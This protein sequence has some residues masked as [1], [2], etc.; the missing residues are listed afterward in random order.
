MQ[1]VSALPGLER[2]LEVCRRRAHPLKHEPPLPP[3][4]SGADFVAGQPMDPQLA[5]LHSRVGYLWVR[6]E[7]YVFPERHAH[8]PDLHQVNSRWRQDWAEPFGS[9]LVFAKDDRLAYCYATVPSLGDAR[10]LQPVVWV[11]VYEALYAVPVA[12]SLDAFLDTY[13]RYLEAAPAF[14]ADDAP[15][16]R[17]FP[18]SASPFI[19]RD[20]EL[21][22]R[23]RAGHFDSLLGASARAREWVD[24]LARA[25][26]SR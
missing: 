1:S 26:V 16:L 2:L 24:A 11:D 15:P 9:L 4:R 13:A 7:L 6:D 17:S 3:G 14:H 22:T 8:R 12:S 25:S 18:W 23:L 5:A 10:G 20:R 19:A 21:V